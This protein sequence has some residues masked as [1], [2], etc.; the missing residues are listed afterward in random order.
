MAEWVPKLQLLGFRIW[1][2]SI[3]E[4]RPKSS[5]RAQSEIHVPERK[6]EYL[7]LRQNRIFKPA[8]FNR[9]IKK[10]KKYKHVYCLF[11]TMWQKKVN[12]QKLSYQLRTRLSG[13]SKSSNWRLVNFQARVPEFDISL[14]F[15]IS[16]GLVDLKI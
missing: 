2:R 15:E 1:Q 5:T 7:G 9:A 14:V 16:S 4:L 13:N 8:I 6:V 11:W 12:A 3:L 10:N